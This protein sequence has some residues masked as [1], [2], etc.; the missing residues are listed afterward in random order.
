M[1]GIQVVMEDQGIAVLAAELGQGA[2]ECLA[3]PQV[4]VKGGGQHKNLGGANPG[5]FSKHSIQAVFAGVFRRMHGQRSQTHARRE[6]KNARHRL[7]ERIRLLARAIP[8]GLM[9]K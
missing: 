6:P 3:L 9:W 4:P 5:F 1:A 2:A 7:Y 8:V